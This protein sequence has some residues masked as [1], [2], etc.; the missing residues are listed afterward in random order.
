LSIVSLVALPT[1]AACNAQDAPTAPLPA[2]AADLPVILLTGFEPFGPGR[3]PNPSWEAIRTLDGREW[4]GHRL[5][6]RQLEVVW[7]EPLV[8]LQSWIDELRPVAVFSFGQGGG[9]TLESQASNR[10]GG[11]PDNKQQ[12]PGQP[13]IV[14]DG[15]EKLTAS[16]DCQALAHQLSA[17]G[18]PIRVSQ[19]AGQYLCE[20]CLY[21]LEYLKLKH[22]LAASV[23]FCHVPP[24]GA[25]VAGRA[26]DAGYVQQFV[27]DLLAAWQALY[28]AAPSNQPQPQADPRTAEVKQFVETY[29]RTWSNRQ[30]D[31]YAEC[32]HSDAVIQFIDSQGRARNQSK[33]P[34]CAEQRSVQSTSPAVEVPT[35]IDIRFEA[36][37]ARAVVAWKLTQGRR[38]ETGYDHFTLIKLGG[39]WRIVNLVFYG[40][41]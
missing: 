17:K 23:L 2:A 40:T 11:S 3:P 18:Y 6:S 22:K 16:T 4:N 24:L 27:L 31:A 8:K 39:R 7:G 33:E 32:F 26:V 38:V 29:F 41:D 37:L 36:K 14:S 34:F 1:M 19:Q 15:P 9:F 30:M 35:S 13:T 10:R 25:S 5:A 20:E 28:Q 12:R 21:S